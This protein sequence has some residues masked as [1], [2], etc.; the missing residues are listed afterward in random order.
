MKAVL[1]AIDVFQPTLPQRERLSASS[2]LVSVSKFQP[3]LPQRE[4]Q[5]QGV[6][7]LGDLDISTHAPTKGATVGYLEAVQHTV[8][9]THAPTKGATSAEL[10]RGVRLK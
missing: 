5:R 7:I 8:I 9:S 2:P 10:P 4:R 6:I 3:T 1:G